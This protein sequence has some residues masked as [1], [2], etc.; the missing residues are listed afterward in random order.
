MLQRVQYFGII[1]SQPLILIRSYQNIDLSFILY[2]H[3]LLG[4]TFAFPLA[5]GVFVCVVPLLAI[6]IL[7]GE[8]VD[9]WLQLLGWRCRLEPVL[10]PAGETPS[11]LSSDMLLPARLGGRLLGR[12]PGLLAGRLDGLPLKPEVGGVS[13]LLVLGDDVF[14]ERGNLNPDPLS[15]VSDISLLSGVPRE[16]F[17]GTLRAL[18]SR[19]FVI[20]PADG[21][22]LPE[23]FRDAPL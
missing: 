8:P 20:G 14:P 3:L 11:Q 23:R 6:G 1:V 2:F 9:D 17:M 16:R 22:E 4:S 5:V 10:R 7:D 15:V 21:M 13:K 19:I 12:L 18:F